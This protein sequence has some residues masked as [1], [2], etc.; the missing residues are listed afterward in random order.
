LNY[1]HLFSGVLSRLRAKREPEGLGLDWTRRKDKIETSKLLR[2]CEQIDRWMSSASS[3][4]FAHSAVI[5][6]SLFYLGQF[7]QL[8]NKRGN[9]ITINYTGGRMSSI[10]DTVGRQITIIYY[11]DNRISNITLPDGNVYTYVYSPIFN[12]IQV[13]S[14]Y[15]YNATYAYNA[16]HN[17]TYKNDM[18]MLAGYEENYFGYATNNRVVWMKNAR[19]EGENTIAYSKV[20]DEFVTTVIDAKG[21]ARKHTHYANGMLKSVEDE[22]GRITSYDRDGLIFSG[23]RLNGSRAGLH[24]G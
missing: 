14:C 20:G 11:V 9:T 5:P 15:G 3:A 1:K 13:Y 22:L 17:I 8:R 4:F 10:V 18:K 24:T 2:S 19:I 16:N 6:I 23:V 12:L 7:T 21:H